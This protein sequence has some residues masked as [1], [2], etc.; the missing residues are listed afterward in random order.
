MADAAIQLRNLSYSYDDIRVLTDVHLDIFPGDSASIVGPNGGGKTTLI[1]LILGLISPDRGTVRVYGNTPE[2]ERTRIGYVP[3][4]ARYDPSYPI[5]V[6]E[7]VCMGRLGS[8]FSGR[9]TRHDKEVAQEALAA[10]NLAGLCKRSFSALSGGQRQ[11]VLIARALAAEGDIL[12]LDE[13]TASLDSQ[14]EEQLFSLLAELNKNMIILMVTHEIGVSPTFFQRIICVNN[15]V[16]V[17]PTSELTGELLR[18]MYGGDLRMIRHDHR[19]GTG[20]HEHD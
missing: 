20:G 15:Q 8:T 6:L 19:C 3:Q 5:S 18:D 4:Y 2:Q 11:R 12:I 9:Y 13:P 16:Y 10:V 1:K 17:H 14:S 7:V